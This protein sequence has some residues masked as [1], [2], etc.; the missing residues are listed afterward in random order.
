MLPG[1]VL[2]TS[3]T[4]AP[5]I[6]PRGSQANL[7]T[8]YEY[9][10]IALQNTSAGLLYQVWKAE[11]PNPTAGNIL[12]SAPNTAPFTWL[13]IPG[14]T[15]LSLTFDQNMLP[16]LAYVLNGNCY[17]YWFSDVY[18]TF[19]TSQLEAGAKTPRCSLDD[20]RQASIIGNISDIL[21]FYT[22]AGELY[23][24]QQRD[25]Y[26][27]I[28]NAD[29]TLPTRLANATVVDCGMNTSQYFQI[30]LQGIAV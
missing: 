26:A 2:A 7:L 11:C 30:L 5:F 17:Y 16:F 22:V 1:N 28:R 4:V 20:K 21:L 25:R 24:R 9:G 10:G 3:P 29:L 19:V 27:T 12:L 13:I 15:E 23:Y 6:A 8:S 18:N 14:I